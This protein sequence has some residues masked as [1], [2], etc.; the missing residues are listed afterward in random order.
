MLPLAGVSTIACIIALEVLLYYKMWRTT[1][2]YRLVLYMFTSLIIFNLCEIIFLSIELWLQSAKIISSTA[3]FSS[4]FNVT[5]TIFCNGS[6]VIFF[7]LMTCITVCIYLMALH[8]YQFTYKSDLCLLISSILYL[9]IVVVIIIVHIGKIN[10]RECIHIVYVLLLNLTIPVNIVFT[11]LTLVPLCC[12]AC[13][14]NLCM[15]TAAT[16][17]S[18]R[19]ALR[20]ILPLFI[21]I[22]P[23]V[24][25]IILQLVVNTAG[26]VA[27]VVSHAILMSSGLVSSLSF[28]LHLCF[29]R[30]NL[31]KLRS[32]KKTTGMINYGSINLRRTHRTTA[33]TSE[34]ISETCNTEYLP[35]SESGEVTRFFLLQNQV[36]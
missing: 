20:E 23:S 13:G 32:K 36:Q 34:G 7:T 9:M 25:V 28:A 35:V 4:G 29:I 19:K 3:C 6:M 22:V 1:F 30:K 26:N 10:H 11:A 18:H 17:E 16:I 33:Y 5:A 8:N 2:I 21:L 24:L 12:R 15:K 27:V 14:Y 31:K